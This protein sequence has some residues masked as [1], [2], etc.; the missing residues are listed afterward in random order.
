MDDTLSK[1]Y[2]LCV[3]LG[4]WVI[5]WSLGVCMGVDELGRECMVLEVKVYNGNVGV[6]LECTASIMCGREGVW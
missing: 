3:C 6:L 5:E 4:V 2:C 1:D